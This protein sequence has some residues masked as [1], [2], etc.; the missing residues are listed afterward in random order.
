[1]R[2]VVPQ[3]SFI[4]IAYSHL[5]N[6]TS[7]TSKQPCRAEI[8]Q[9][10]NYIFSGRKKPQSRRQTPLPHPRD[11]VNRRAV[12]IL[13]AT[14]Y[15]SFYDLFRSISQLCGL[16]PLHGYNYLSPLP[17][18]CNGARPFLLTVFHIDGEEFRR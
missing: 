13:S 17:A 9:W 10:R 16:F 7:V 3:L 11:K 18:V 8:H 14:E 15:C 5:L 6:R 2:G 1:M 4:S 12:R